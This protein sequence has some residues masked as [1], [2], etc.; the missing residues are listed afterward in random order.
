[1]AQGAT[2]TSGQEQRICLWC[3]GSFWPKDR[4][5][6]YCC[7][8]C[9]RSYQNKVLKWRGKLPVR[10]IRIYSLARYRSRPLT[11]DT[12]FLVQKWSAEGLSE[13]TIGHILSRPLVDVQ[14]AQLVPL[15]GYQRVM[16]EKI[17]RAH[18]ADRE[19]GKGA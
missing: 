14:R 6:K 1:M 15:T 12:A 11:E 10:R 16:V 2:R 18:R 8:A 19:E 13:N 17:R 7:P 9:R 5:Q 3:S 4:R